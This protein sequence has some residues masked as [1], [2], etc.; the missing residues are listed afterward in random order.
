MGWSRDGADKMARLRAFKA[1]KG[2]VIE[3]IR[4]KK[5]RGKTLYNNEKDSEGN[6]TRFEI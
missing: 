6:I 5:K 4:A 3:Y 1:N 2:R